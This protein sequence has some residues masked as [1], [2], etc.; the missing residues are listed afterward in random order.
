MFALSMELVKGLPVI[1]VKNYQ[2]CQLPD[3][4]TPQL[5]QCL[6]EL[7]CQPLE[8][9]A[10]PLVLAEKLTTGLGADFCL[11]S[12]ALE[13]PW[14]WSGT[15]KQGRWQGKNFIEDLTQV[16]SSVEGTAISQ[17]SATRCAEGKELWL[18]PENLPDLNSV[19]GESCQRA[20]VMKTYFQGNCNGLVMV[21]Y[22]QKKQES[23]R[24]KNF[25]VELQTSLGIINQLLL[26]T[27][28]KANSFLEKLSPSSEAD[29]SFTLPS[30]SQRNPFE[31]SPILKVWYDASRQQLEQQKQ[32]NQQL[33]SNIITIMSDQTRN[34]LANIRMGIEIL[35]KSP[36]SPKKLQ[37]KLGIIEQ[38]W[39]KL[40]DI[41]GKLLQ[42]QE[43][44]QGQGVVQSENF[45]VLSLLR[46]TIPPQEIINKRVSL[47][48]LEKSYGVEANLNHLQQIFQELL[49]NAKKFSVA[50]SIIKVSLGN[51]DQTLAQGQKMVKLTF[52]NLTPAVDNKN[53]KYFF[54]PFYREQW[55]IDAAIAGI[56]L[57]LTI[58]KTLVEQLN[59]RIDVAWEPATS[60]DQ[61]LITFT[62]LIPGSR[63]S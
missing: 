60:P 11:W 13:Q 5:G 28:L 44:K 3:L 48:Y 25:L 17:R 43:L 15:G 23:K 58:I 37:E 36:P 31:E 24:R 33:I 52:G 6:I 8:Q 30:S 20:V 46:D 1:K 4:M 38:E 61:S 41:N 59:G 63:V 56:G 12:I 19:V 21:G 42:L 2:F 7:V 51:Y 22:F 55:V 9:G 47:D 62:L 27:E 34:P 26:T 49:T 10:L 35:R 50:D 14:F 54:E 32:W 45:D 29:I 53:T 39:R 57:G 40:N 16:L 18:T